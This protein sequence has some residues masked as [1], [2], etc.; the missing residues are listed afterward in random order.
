MKYLIKVRNFSKKY[1][2]ENVKI[3]DITITNRITLIAG[4]NGCGKSTLLKALGGF[5][6]YDG[7]VDIQ[8]KT[9][10]MS[11][12]TSFPSDLTIDDF[13]NS[14][15]KISSNRTLKEELSN[16]YKIFNLTSKIYHFLSSLSKGM[17]A[18]VNL[19]QILM[20]KADIYLLDEPINGL[21]K[22]GVN[23]LIEY[24]RISSKIFVIST[25]LID[26]FKELECEVI[27]L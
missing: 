12:F 22:E 4:K 7:D 2:K 13:I 15:N 6:G 18:K 17:K 9:A 21:D 27:N 23:C 3:N 20:E 5:I 8:G 14:L 16:L 24:L 1:P 25:H 19:V 10:Y 26:D 11:E